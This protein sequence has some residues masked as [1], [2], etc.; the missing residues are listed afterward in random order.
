MRSQVPNQ[1]TQHQTPLHLWDFSEQSWLSSLELG[2]GSVQ[3]MPS[4]TRLMLNLVQAHIERIIGRIT[5]F[6]LLYSTGRVSTY[7]NLNDVIMQL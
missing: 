5:H 6:V 7:K 3:Q 2:P 1:F 4:R